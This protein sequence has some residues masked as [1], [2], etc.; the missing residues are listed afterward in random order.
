MIQQIGSVDDIF[1]GIVK[2]VLSKVI[3]T[4][5][6]TKVRMTISLESTGHTASLEERVQSLLKTHATPKCK[7]YENLVL[8]ENKFI[9]NLNRQHSL[10][11]AIL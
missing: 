9:I 4:L 6:P 11:V 10:S 3:H 7:Y 1:T 8:D 2:L 5:Q